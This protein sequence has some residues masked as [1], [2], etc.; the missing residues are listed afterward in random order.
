MEHDMTPFLAAK[1]D[2]L[3]V[4]QDVAL[5]KQE[6]HHFD[7][8]MA[9]RFKALESSISL[10][11]ENFESRLVAKLGVLA[12]MLFSAALALQVLLR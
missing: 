1:N 12:T 10:K 6:I 9:I 3:I 4:K 11:L 8:L 5:L 2:Q 7:Q